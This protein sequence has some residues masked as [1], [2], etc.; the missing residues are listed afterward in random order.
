MADVTY[1][2]A[3][4]FVM[5]DDGAAPREGVECTSAIAAIM[6]AEVLSRKEEDKERFEPSFLYQTV[7]IFR[8]V[9]ILGLV[10]A[11]RCD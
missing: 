4:P 6:R 11:D 1:Y 7:P 2:V 5:S 10:E 3:L 8:L 9:E